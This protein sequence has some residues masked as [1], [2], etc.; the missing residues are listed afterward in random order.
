MYAAIDDP[1]CY[2]GT[3]VLINK[4]GLQSQ[5][6]LDAFESEI[7]LQRS[8]ESLPPGRLSYTHY[9]AIHRHLFQDVYNWAGK[10][11]TVRISKGE[12]TFCYPEH[13]N[14]EMAKLFK[15]LGRARHVRGTS[16][17]AFAKQAAHFLAS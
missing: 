16:P 7:S 9:R 11:R 4:L 8:T 3:T 10:V 5:H 13:I 6:E 14:Q 1:Y 12:S 17:Q 2:P 15:A